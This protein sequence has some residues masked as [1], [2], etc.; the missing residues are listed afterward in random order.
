MIVAGHQTN[1]PSGIF[2]VVRMAFC[3]LAGIALARLFHLWPISANA[4]TLT[5]IVSAMLVFLFLWLDNLGTLTVFGFAGLIFGLAYAQG[6]ISRFVTTGP[7]MFL[8]KISFS[9]YMIHI[10]PLNLFEWMLQDKIQEFGI[11]VRL[12]SL[13]WIALACLAIAWCTYE[14]VELPFQRV[15]RKVA[16]G[17]MDARLQFKRKIGL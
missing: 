12:F 16:S 7:I 8:G 14:L 17:S 4:A 10:I 2:G 6:P 15:G 1:N 9:F 3:F 5:T 13:A 11:L